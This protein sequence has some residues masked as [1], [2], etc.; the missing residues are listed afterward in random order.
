MKRQVDDILDELLVL[1]CQD[2]EAGAVDQLF[3]RWQP[4]LRRHAWRMTGEHDLADDAVQDAWMA[5]LRGLSRLS[6]PATFPTWAY[7]IV[8]RKVVD[9][10]RRKQRQRRAQQN[11]A[12]QTPRQPPGWGWR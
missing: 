5:I 7:R 11:L 10:I 9:L 6:D 8:T 4:R 2:G 12:D 1:R 3:R